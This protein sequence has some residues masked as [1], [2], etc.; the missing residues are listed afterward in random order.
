MLNLNALAARITLYSQF[1]M[2]KSET[3]N[4]RYN[5]CKKG[6]FPACS[7]MAYKGSVG[8]AAL[9][10]NLCTRWSEWLI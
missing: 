7:M 3:T 8:I 9:I 5:K 2:S 4:N 6:F 10:V 1:G